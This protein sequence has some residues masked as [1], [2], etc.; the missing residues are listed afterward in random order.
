MGG[1]LKKHKEN[2]SR[3]KVRLMEGVVIVPDVFHA[4][5]I[6]ENVEE[7]FRTMKILHRCSIEGLS[8]S[9]W[10]N[11]RNGAKKI[12]STYQ[13]YQTKFGA[14]WWLKKH[15]PEKLAIKI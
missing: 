10:E 6:Q 4:K 3:W 13:R 7:L 8:Q 14:Y 2:L 12:A 11:V 9:P 15:C 1:F 5:N